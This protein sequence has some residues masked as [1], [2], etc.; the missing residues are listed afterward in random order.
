MSFVAGWFQETI[1][2]FLETF[3]AER[4]PDRQLVVH[5]DADLYS[6]ALYV[7][8]RL[9]ALMVPGTIV[10]FDEFSSVLN[11]FQALENYCSAYLREYDVV[12]HAWYY[13]CQVAI[14]LR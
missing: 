9:D 5:V 8:T 10:V 12:A 14:K 3:V 13:F 1:D 2:G 4:K 11:E 6:S 7:L